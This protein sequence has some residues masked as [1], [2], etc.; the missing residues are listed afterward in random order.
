[1]SKVSVLATWAPLRPPLCL[2]INTLLLYLYLVLYL[3]VQYLGV[4]AFPPYRDISQTGLGPTLMAFFV[5]LT[6]LTTHFFLYIQIQSHPEALMIRA[7]T[8]KL[9]EGDPIH[10]YRSFLLFIF[11]SP[12]SCESNTLL[13]F[14]ISKGDCLEGPC[15]GHEHSGDRC[16]VMTK[17]PFIPFITATSCS[18]VSPWLGVSSSWAETL[19]CLLP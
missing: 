7:S 9:R 13:C 2:Q 16:L 6:C 17:V 19:Q 4:S 18:Q 15:L 5:P 1:M 12:L 3:C 8:Y 11:P 10:P 14:S